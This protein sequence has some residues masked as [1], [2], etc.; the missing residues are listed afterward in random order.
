MKW[1]P[2]GWGARITS[3]DAPGGSYVLPVERW[4]WWGR[5]MVAHESGRLIPAKRVP[6]FEKL[7]PLHRT[8]AVVPA[9]PGWKVHAH[10]FGDLPAYSTPIAAWVMS[11]DGVF[12]PVAAAGRGNDPAPSNPDPDGEILLR[13]HMSSRCRIIGPDLT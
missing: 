2:T 12:W 6:G 8:V 3:E 4:S 9:A 5:A 11:G 7:V 10:A 13:P 1:S